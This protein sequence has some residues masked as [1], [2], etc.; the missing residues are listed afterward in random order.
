MIAAGDAITALGIGLAGAG[1][2]LGMCGGIAASINLGGYRG[3]G[4]TLAYHAG[5]ITSYALLG[6]LLAGAAGAID[7]AQWTMGLR[8]LAAML[9]IAMGL[10]IGGWWQGIAM[11]ERAGARLWRPVQRLSGRLLP[12]RHRWQAL[13]LGLGW[14]LMPCGLIYSALAWSATS[15]QALSGALLMLLFG[16]GTLPAMLTTSFGAGGVQALLRRRGL[17]QVIAVFLIASGVWSLSMTYRHGGHLSGPIGAGG[18]STM[19][20]GSGHGGAGKPGE[21]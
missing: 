6:A 18:A 13:L 8:Y 1:H 17:K 14:G 7:L 5:R 12:V 16:A 20:H 3:T 4:A 11:L 10:S 2:C 21:S 9:L 15:Q 19:Q